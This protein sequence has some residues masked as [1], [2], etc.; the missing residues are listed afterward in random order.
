M[1]AL[2]RWWRE[3]DW[4]ERVIAG[5]LLVVVPYLLIVAGRQWS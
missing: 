5:L 1:K 3:S 4:N 2:V